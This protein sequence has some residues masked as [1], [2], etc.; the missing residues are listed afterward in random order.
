MVAAALAAVA[1]L[2]VAYGTNLQTVRL[3]VVALAIAIAYPFFKRFLAIPQAFLGIAFSFGIPMAFT[4]VLRHVAAAGLDAVRGQPVLGGRLRHRVRD[5]RPRR[6]HPAGLAHVRD[7]FRPLRRRRRRRLLCACI[8]PALAWIAFDAR[9]GTAVLGWVGGGRG[10]CR[11]S[12]VAHPHPRA[13]S[14]LPRV[15]VQSLAGLRGVCRRRAGLRGPVGRVAAA[16]ID[17]R[18]AART[19]AGGGRRR[20][21]ADPRQLSGRSFARR[22][23]STTRIRA[24]TSG[25]C[26]RA[27]WTNR[28]RRCPIP[29]G[30]RASRRA[31]S[32]VWDTIV[33]CTRD[34]EPRFRDSRSR[35]AARSAACGRARRESGSSASTAGPR[36]ARNGRWRAA[37]YA[38]LVLPS[39]SPAYTRPFAEKLAAWRAIAAFL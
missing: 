12:P 32:R 33:A 17:C 21:R 36:R 16:C 38:T 2:L 30:S 20:A 5:G 22:A 28:C 7:H 3:S 4:A 27:C 18:P 23:C 25:R 10:V 26:S 1:F 6:R 8:S 39:S 15:P 9:H 19:A 14:L 29:R 31:A 11:L 35:S 34:R 24:I 37:G 13:R